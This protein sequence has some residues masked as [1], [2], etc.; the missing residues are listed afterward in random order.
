MGDLGHRPAGQLV[1]VDFLVAFDP[2][3]DGNHHLHVGV[4]L[5][6]DLYDFLRRLMADEDWRSGDL[7]PLDSMYLWIFAIIGRT[8]RRCPVFRIPSTNWDSTL[9]MLTSLITRSPMTI[10][11]DG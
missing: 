6:V 8:R 7:G 5:Q 9:L 10:R 1:A 11:V 4:V 3:G 2:A